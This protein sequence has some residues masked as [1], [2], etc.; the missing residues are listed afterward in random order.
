MSHGA[1]LRDLLREAHRS[2]ARMPGRSLLTASSI[3][4][5]VLSIVAVI[6]LATTAVSD[7]GASFNRLKATT[8]TVTLT[9]KARENATDLVFPTDASARIRRLN[10]V[11]G[12]TLAWGIDPEVTPLNVS[13]RGH[14]ADEYV[15]VYAADEGIGTLT[16]DGDD[17]LSAHEVSHRSPVALVGTRFAKQH[18]LD[19]GHLPV[20]IVINNEV[21]HVIGVADCHTFA[22]HMESAIIIPI[23]EALARFGP[24]RGKAQATLHIRTKEGAADLISHQAVY[25]LDARAPENYQVSA[26]ADW[27][28]ATKPVDATVSGLLIATTAVIVVMMVLSVTTT[29]R[30]AA[31]ERTGEFALRR[32]LGARQEDLVWQILVESFLVGATGA[33]SGGAIGIGV[34]A[35]VSYWRSWTPTV[36]PILLPA[37]VGLGIVAAGIGGLVVARGMR[38]RSV[39]ETLKRDS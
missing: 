5:G 13:L 21:Y 17:L 15:P 25:A 34:V 14:P 29:T 39:A 32:S 38:R 1:T 7:I 9:K 24:P 33:S 2:V 20:D 27:D 6:G 36:S 8:V 26:P 37:A 4:I 28:R 11:K 12:A 35:V 30:A 22:S 16:G 19:P 10:G 18:Q 31:T 3:C 23:T